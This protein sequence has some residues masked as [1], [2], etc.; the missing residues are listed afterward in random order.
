M[1]DKGQRHGHGIKAFPSA[2]YSIEYYEG[3]MKNGRQQD[4]WVTKYRNGVWECSHGWE[5]D[6]LNGWPEVLL[7]IPCSWSR[8]GVLACALPTPVPRN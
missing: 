7:S 1:N 5:N 2:D 8:L 6:A 3:A 4:T